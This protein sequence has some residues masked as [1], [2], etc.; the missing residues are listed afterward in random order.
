LLEVIEAWARARLLTLD[1]HP[2]SREPTVEVAHEALLREWPRLRAWLQEDREEIVVL[3]HLREAATSWDQLDRDPGALYRGARLDTALGL[4]DGRAGALP[5]LEREFLDASREER[6]RERQREVEQLER[7]A[8]ANRRLRAQLVALAIAL[9]IALV[10][11]LVAVR[12]RDRA[13]DERQVATAERRIASARELAAAANANLDIDPE[14]SILLALAAVDQT[15]SADDS[16]LP[17]AQEA[18]HAAVTRSLIELRVPGLGGSLDWSPDGTVFVTEGPEYT[19]IVDIR[20]ART[21]ESLRSWHGHDVDVND[22]AFNADGTMLATTGEDGAARV[23]DAGTSEELHA[24]EGSTGEVWGPSFSPDGS[25]FAAAWPDEGVVRVLDLAT[26]RVVREIRAIAAPS[27]TSFGPGGTRIAVASLVDAKPIVVDTASGETVFTL[28]RHPFAV[29]D[30][31]WSPDGASIAT[32]GDD[33]TVRIFDAGTGRSR[34]ALLGHFFGV[35]EVD[36]S[37]GSGALVTASRDGTAKLW[38]LYGGG[39]REL[40]TLTAQDTRSGIDGVAFSPDGSR[41]IT[42]NTD[43]S[44]ARVWDVGR[45]GHAEVTNLVMTQP[46]LP[47]ATYTPDGRYLLSTGPGGSVTVWDAQ[48]F[49]YVRSLGGAPSSGTP[50]WATTDSIPPASSPT[51][52]GQISVSDDGRLVAAAGP[53]GVRVWD[54]GSGKEAFALPAQPRA[55]FW[56]TVDWSPSGDLLAVSGRETVPGAEVERGLVTIVDRTGREVSVLR[57][58]P[59]VGAGLPVFSSDGDRL[60]TSR[61][62]LGRDDPTKAQVAIWDWRT[63]TAQR[64]FGEELGRA[65]ASP[66]GNLIAVTRSTADVIEVWDAATAQRVATLSGHTGAVRAAAFSPDGSRLASTGDDGT[67]RLWDPGTGEQMLVLRGHIA[68]VSSVAFSP[69]G[70]QLVSAGGEGIAR[71]WALD[72]DDL[73]EIA[74]REL[75]RTFTD[76]ECRQYLHLPTCP[77]P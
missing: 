26:G 16:V 55:D 4:A 13:E 22:V 64:T 66:V 63:G 46:S 58:D 60:V 39:G 28:D 15:R 73:I 6:D 44:A 7:K 45:N 48:A 14:R 69:D 8:R 17:E 62:P 70:S 65:F 10:V 47:A 77:S 37:P 53:S 35:R 31:D 42:G 21:G 9:V 34:L 72:L 18:L 75:T 54:L 40:M 24:V 71:V 25:L 27:D 43:I 52:V 76:A 57:E 51:D 59:G 74:E 33:G 32:A 5:T 38:T 68:A 19:G 49:S 36:W 50:G 56:P 20:D 23:W 2:E 3:G 29:R 41:V 67:V 1:R 61:V 12:Q 11:G 30:V